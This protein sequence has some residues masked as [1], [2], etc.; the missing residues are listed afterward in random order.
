MLH[1]KVGCI[2]FSVL[3]AAKL[4]ETGF[5]N[6]IGLLLRRTLVLKEQYSATKARRHKA[7]FSRGKMVVYSFLICLY[8]ASFRGQLQG[9][10][11]FKFIANCTYV[12]NFKP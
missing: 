9:L 11:L 10:K 3:P 2:L 1:T 5:R 4:Q 7:C 6:T 8:V 12:G